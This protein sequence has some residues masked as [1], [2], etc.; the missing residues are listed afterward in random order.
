M[1]MHSHEVPAV[2]YA[3]L[4]ATALSEDL[5]PMGDVS[6]HLVDAALMATATFRSRSVGVLAGTAFI[7]ETARQVDPSISTDLLLVDG[8]LLRVGGVVGTWHGP[9]RSILAAER[10]ALN[11]LCHLSG[12][13]ST[14]R[15][16]VDAVVG[17]CSVLD[18]RKTTPGLR[19][20]EKAA[21]RAGGGRNHRG[22]L[23]EMVMLKDNHLTGVSIGEGVERART[24]WPYRTIEVECDDLV[25]VEEA[26]EAGADAVLLDNM[27]HEEVSSAVAVVEQWRSK[28]L[29]CLIEVSGGITLDTIAGYASL[30]AD[31]ISVGALTHSARAHDIGLDIA[32]D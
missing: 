10:T 8:S 17:Q 16:Y 13:A 25:Q 15:D 4:V 3:R 24:L 9:L 5:L 31:G 30:G 26:L 19:S 18:T 1:T 2:E 32:S 22:S 27:S 28:G 12:V 29:R 6:A 11:F 7:T 21:V 20:V 23:S 14:T